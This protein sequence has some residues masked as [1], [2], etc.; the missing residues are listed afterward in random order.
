[1]SYQIRFSGDDMGQIYQMNDTIYLF[2]QG[3]TVAVKAHVYHQRMASW[4]E[5]RMSAPLVFEADGTRCTLTAPAGS[6]DVL[7]EL[8]AGT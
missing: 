2:D 6:G 8:K 7:I 3:L 5:G 4:I 1:M